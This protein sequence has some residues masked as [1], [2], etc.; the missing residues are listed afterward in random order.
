MGIVRM[1]FLNNEGHLLAYLNLPYF[2]K[3]YVLTRE[4][5]NMIV[6]IINYMVVLILLTIVLAVI[7]SDKITTP[8]RAI[9]AKIGSFRLGK[10]YEHI[11]Y[12]EKDEIGSLVDAYNRMIDE[13]A[14]NVELLARSE[15]ESAWRE[16]AKQVAHEI[17]N[18]LTPM[19]LSVQQLQRAYREKKENFDAMFVKLTGTLIEQIDRL[20]NIASAFSNFARLP[21]MK[22]EPVDLVRLLQDVIYLFRSQ[23]EIV[24]DLRLPE[25]KE[26][27]VFADKELLESVF[28]N[29]IKNAVQA[30]TGREDGR[31]EVFFRVLEQNGVVQVYV[32]DNGEGI[33][34]GIGNR[35]FEPNFTTKSSGMGMGLAIVKKI[36]EGAGGRV[37]YETREGEGTTFIVELFLYMR[38]GG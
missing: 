27:W 21:K 3:Q 31:I 32:R 16:M 2:T 5:S 10:E 30:L 8:L 37:W 13:L 9:Q 38:E 20:S 28:S 34:E 19:K 1:P 12:R 15:R 4:I 7:I 35:L 33:P 23:H 22:N 36:V 17:K 11:M 18:P 29:L 24:F 26:V 25:K 6:G 14:R